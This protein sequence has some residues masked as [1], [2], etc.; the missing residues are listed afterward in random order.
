MYSTV[1]FNLPNT[2]IFVVSHWNWSC[3]CFELIYCSLW[4]ITVYLCSRVPI[5]RYADRGCVKGFNLRFPISQTH[6][7]PYASYLVKS[8][9]HRVE[10]KATSIIVVI[11]AQKS[12][13]QKRMYM[14]N[15]EELCLL[16]LWTPPRVLVQVPLACAYSTGKIKLSAKM[17]RNQY[18]HRY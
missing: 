15:G 18:H 14:L 13:E 11:I 12:H 9:V 2:N 3:S 16:T 1:L 5:L 10:I 6:D 8:H 7:W 4:V 17:T